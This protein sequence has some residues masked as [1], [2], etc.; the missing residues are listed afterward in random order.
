[1]EAPY[2]GMLDRLQ[3]ACERALK[4]YMR[5]C[6]EGGKLLA[7]IET[8]PISEAALGEIVAHRHEEMHA[9]TAYTSART[10]LWKYLTAATAVGAPIGSPSSLEV[11]DP[12]SSLV[13]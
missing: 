5:A 6:R 1:M 4:D 10:K 13:K 11:A 3:R 7:A 9:H 12:G 2:D 8:L